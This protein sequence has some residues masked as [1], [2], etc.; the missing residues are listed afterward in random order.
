MLRA[1]DGEK[2]TPGA[3]IAKRNAC[4]R[5]DNKKNRGQEMEGERD[6]VERDVKNNW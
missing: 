3:K 4:Q 5:K 1:R 2:G 6:V